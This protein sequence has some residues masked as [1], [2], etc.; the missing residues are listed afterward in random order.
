M[1]Q[2]WYALFP[3]NT[4]RYDVGEYY[5]GSGSRTP[6]VYWLNDFDNIYS[7]FSECSETVEAAN[8][9]RQ[10]FF[11]VHSIYHLTSVTLYEEMV[12]NNWYIQMVKKLFLC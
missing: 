10:Q 5:A 7:S 11:F 4:S 12:V 3:S 8:S 9:A 1:Q 2:L 6:N